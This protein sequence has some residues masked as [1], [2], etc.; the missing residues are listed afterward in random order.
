MLSWWTHHCDSIKRSD[1]S[2]NTASNVALLKP[3]SK[4]D[5][6]NLLQRYAPAS[7]LNTSNSSSVTINRSH[8]NHKRAQLPHATQPHL[9]LHPHAGAISPIPHHA[10]TT[11]RPN[12]TGTPHTSNRSGRPSERQEKESTSH[13]IN[14]NVDLELARESL[15]NV[16]HTSTVLNRSRSHIK[17][18]QHTY[19]KSPRKI[20]IS[21]LNSI[22]S[23]NLELDRAIEENRKRAMTE[24]AASERPK[25]PLGSPNPHGTA[26]RS[27]TYSPQKSHARKNY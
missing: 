20:H 22:N 5:I 8:H 7:K 15:I 23:L 2:D 3:N 24:A 1:N 21:N 13:Q 10:H 6:Q 27:R 17:P 4:P 26:A 11:F 12:P 16:S 19:N 14:S 18:L 9:H 25:T